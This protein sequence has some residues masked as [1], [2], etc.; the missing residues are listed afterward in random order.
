MNDETPTPRNEEPDPGG[1]RL[2]AWQQELLEELMA[3][4]PELGGL[5]QEGL[6]LVERLESPGVGHILAHVG[7]ELTRGVV[8]ALLETDDQLSPEDLEEISENENHR[9]KSLT[10]WV[11]ERRIRRFPS[12]LSFTSFSLVPLIIEEWETPQ[13]RVGCG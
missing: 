8:T 10:A 4:D 6:A 2:S 1:Q 9:G 12:G 13:I 3:L 11:C 5:Y 7:R